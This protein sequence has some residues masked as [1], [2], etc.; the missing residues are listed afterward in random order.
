MSISKLSFR[1]LEE[2]LYWA[3][4]NYFQISHDSLMEL[5][6]EWERRMD[7]FIDNLDDFISEIGSWDISFLKNWVAVTGE[8]YKN[9]GDD[10]GA[11]NLHIVAQQELTK[12]ISR[13]CKGGLYETN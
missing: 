3:W 5:Q 1:E 13:C 6:H 12:S 9:Y 4:N 2:A 7:H 10:F 8:L 11:K